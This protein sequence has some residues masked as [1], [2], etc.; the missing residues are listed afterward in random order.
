[1]L[2]LISDGASRG[3]DAKVHADVAFPHERG[4][5]GSVD[6][7]VVAASRK[8]F[9]AKRASRTTKSCLR[10]SHESER[11]YK[12]MLSLRPFMASGEQDSEYSQ[13]HCKGGPGGRSIVFYR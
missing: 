6:L 2:V 13:F 12:T 8:S 1:M 9:L 4:P 10:L 5:Q 11:A 3:R 7:S